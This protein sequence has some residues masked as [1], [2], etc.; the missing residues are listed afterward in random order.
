MSEKKLMLDVSQAHELKLAFRRNGWTNAD[1]KALSE[2][3]FL[4]DVLKLMKGQLEIT[5][6]KHLIDTDA[7]PFVPPGMS[8]EKHIGHGLWQW[9]P[10]IIGLFLSKE[11]EKNYQVGTKLREVIEVLKGKIVLN[12]NILDYLLAHP[13]L[14]PEEWKG[15]A[16]FFWGTIYRGAYDDLYVRYLFW[17]GSE[18]RW[19][20]R[21]LDDCFF[22]VDD[23]AALASS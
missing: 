9:N 22:V 19:C 17:R 8:V 10:D 3:K 7:T 13:S 5:P 2:G 18:W 12:A 23:P 21:W 4:A 20:F 6:K 15:K 16:V 14:I 11:Q 1:I